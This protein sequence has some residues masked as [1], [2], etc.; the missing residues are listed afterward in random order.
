MEN[1]LLY[2]VGVVII[3][4]GLAISIALH[5]VGHLIPAKLFGV[6]VTQYMV[7]FGPT[8]FS[9]RRGETEYGFKLIPF[10]GYISMIGMFPPQKAGGKARRA[11]TGFFNTLIQ[12][13]RK[14][15]L[16]TV[17]DDDSRS[18]YRLPVYKRLIIMLGGPT[19]NLLLGILFFGIVLCG[20]GIAGPSTTIGSVSSCVLPASSTRQTCETGDPV[21]PGAAAGI[22]PGDRIETI[23]GTAISTW[24]DATS[25]IRTSSNVP[26]TV[27]VNR[28]GTDTTLTITPLLTQRDATEVVN[29]QSVVKTDSTGAAVTENVGFVGIGYATQLVPQPVTA[30]L[31]FVGT[32]VVGVANT[33][34][35]LPARLVGVADAA[36][37]GG[38]RDVNGP[39]S[40]VGVGRVAGEIATIDIPLA[41]KV[42]TLIGLLGS[43][44]IGLF[45][46]NLVPLMPL[47][48]GHIAGAL[49][50]GL[51]RRVAKLFKRRDPGPVDTAK[52]MPLTFVV[53][54][55]LGGVSAL[56]VYAD[57][58]NPVNLFG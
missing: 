11:T 58:V 9:R 33:I 14:A 18:F 46:I 19:M 7:G 12:D 35:N 38:T 5:E 44:N 3:A 20:F 8:V 54:I 50:E 48:G 37:G 30:V 53:V 52:L 42:A 57:I 16:D 15:S 31:P 41:S 49:W 22:L 47:D 45:V 27:V 40:V 17:G 2:V 34:I 32:N 25:I 23:N 28:G 36:F 10:G 29:G 24:D 39:I 13:A 55:F 21:S 6:K 26:L 1:V 4:L 51:R 56:L 43:V